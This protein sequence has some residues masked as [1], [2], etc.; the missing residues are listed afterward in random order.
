[1]N[2]I[3]I[4]KF[5]GII[6]ANHSFLLTCHNNVDGDALGSTLGLRQLLINMGKEATVVTPDLP[7]SYYSWMP[8]FKTIKA[9]DRDI[10]NCN[11][12]VDAVDVLIMLDFNDIG[13]LDVM[14]DKISSVSKPT[15]IVDHHTNPTLS[16][17]AFLSEPEASATCSILADLIKTVGWS[18]FID[19]DVA[20]NLY[21]GIITDTGGLS[22]SSNN[23]EIYYTVADLLKYG[24]DKM[25]IHDKIFNNKDLRRLKLIGFSLLR[26]LHRV[27][28]LPLT[29]T[30]LTIEDL[31][32]FNYFTGDAEGLVN[33]PLQSKDVI[34]N[35]LILER[36]DMIK[37][38]IRSKGDF[39]VNDFAAQYFE[40]GGHV[41]A[42]GGKFRGSLDD[43]VALYKEGIVKHYEEWLKKK[44]Q[45]S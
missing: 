28:K 6:N 12:I 10:E 26:R 8:G 36:P 44:S 38:S 20:T 14:G 41:N 9:Y 35:A 19:T 3:E 21:T 32:K 29:I 5:V 40:G 39:Y 30:A 33:I 42:A 4:D 13:R 23:P 17:D 37:L 27:A 31:D 25:Y 22:Y 24:I 11:S 15:I 45:Q 43:A 7:P 16:A 34:A 18:N 1:M 2:Q